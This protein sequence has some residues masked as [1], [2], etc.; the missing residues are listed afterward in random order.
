MYVSRRL[1]RES[2]A[3]Y[4]LRVAATDGVFVTTCRVSIEILDDNDNRPIC[5]AGSYA[6]SVEENANAG[7]NV[8]TVVATDADE[9]ANAKQIF[10]L[11]GKDSDMFSIGR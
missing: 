8:V 10:Y 1:D 11:T 5:A 7:T 4:L 9:G 2:Q 3:S 6:A